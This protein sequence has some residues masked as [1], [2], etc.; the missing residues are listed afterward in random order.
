MFIINFVIAH[1]IAVLV[2]LVLLN[3]VAVHTANMIKR[4]EWYRRAIRT[5]V[6]RTKFGLSY[7]PYR[8]PLRIASLAFG[9]VIAMPMSVL[10]LVS[11]VDEWHDARVSARL[12]REESARAILEAERIKLENFRREPLRTDWFANNGATIYFNTV[13]GVTAALSPKALEQ[14]KRDTEYARMD[15]LWLHRVLRPTPETF[16]FVTK[17][18]DELI[19]TN[20]EGMLSRYIS[21]RLSELHAM[22]EKR[23]CALV[24][25]ES[26]FVPLVNETLLSYGDQL[27]I[28][29]GCDRQRPEYQLID[30]QA[31]KDLRPVYQP[32]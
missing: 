19:R 15:E 4:G 3:W 31:P 6:W 7:Y 22:S 32:R 2:Y 8:L 28:L 13:S 29:R 1:W 26:I 30:M 25:D 23:G 16:I 17:S 9:Y 21:G 11:K 27:A 12:F 5:G 10:F 20:F 14:T 24:R 18:G